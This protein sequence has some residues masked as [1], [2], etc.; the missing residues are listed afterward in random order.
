MKNFNVEIV[1]EMFGIESDLTYDAKFV[2][3]YYLLSE[4]YDMHMGLKVGQFIAVDKGVKVD[5]SRH[6]KGFTVGAYATFTNSD[7][8]FTSSQNKGYIDKGIYVQIPLAVFTYKNVKG[9]VNYGMSPWTRDVGQ[10]AGTSMSLYPMNN[11][12]NNIKIM[13]KNIQQIIE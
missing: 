4:K 13:K 6:Y 7:E 10:Y 11:N 5:F 12:E 1:N 8:V 9:R 2:N 3:A